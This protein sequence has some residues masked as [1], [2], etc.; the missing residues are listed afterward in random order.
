MNLIFLIVFSIGATNLVVNAS[1]LEGVRNAVSSK[2][3]LLEKLLSCMMCA[4]FW[5][6]VLSS[7]FF[8]VNPIFGAVISSL[9][10]HLFGVLVGCIESVTYANYQVPQAVGVEYEEQE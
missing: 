7:L 8:G 5:V 2:H 4:G 3:L 9:F 6:G 1:I 10:S